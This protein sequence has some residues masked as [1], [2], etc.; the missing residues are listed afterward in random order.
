VTQFADYLQTMLAFVG[1]RD[2]SI[3]FF[4]NLGGAL[5]GVLLA[6]WIERIIARRSD[7]NYYGNVLLGIRSELRFLRPS[8][9][10]VRDK[11]RA[12]DAAIR[13]SF[14]VPA[15]KTAV[16]N[17]AVHEQC[18]SSLVIVLTVLSTYADDTDESFREGM[19]RQ[20]SINLK[21][22]GAD[23]AVRALH[24]ALAH[25]VD[26]LQ[27]MLGL[28]LERVDAELQRLK[29]SVQPDSAVVEEV[30]RRLHEILQ[31]KKD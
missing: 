12:G 15:V 23:E 11:I 2:F 20:E 14:V 28:A 26:Q 5:F 9:V 7:R 13:Q 21:H 27:D 17:P 10:H 31:R 22:P 3:N 4:A 8:C 18:P 19:E 30:K 24:N 25:R 6:F 16:L 1:S 29:V